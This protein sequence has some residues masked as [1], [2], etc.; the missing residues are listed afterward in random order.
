VFVCG[1]GRVRGGD[2]RSVVAAVEFFPRDSLVGSSVG[3]VSRTVH[4]E[5]PLITESFAS[6]MHRGSFAS[7]MRQC[8]EA[9]GC[10]CRGQSLWS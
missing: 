3:V 6:V 4:W 5:E 8:G 10:M 7:V 1:A 2:L 9:G